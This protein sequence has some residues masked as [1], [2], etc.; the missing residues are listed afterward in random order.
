MQKPKYV[1][2]IDTYQDLAGETAM[3]PGRGTEN[4]DARMYPV[5]K[6]NGEAGELAELY[7]KA[8]RGGW[9]PDREEVRLEIGDVLWYAGEIA[10]MA[11]LS[12]ADCA[13]ANLENVNH[14]K[15]TNTITAHD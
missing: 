1:R 11:G 5:L 9:L 13:N 15:A 14:R 3:Y 4:W 10:A 12:L 8:F 7:G 2:D 6:L